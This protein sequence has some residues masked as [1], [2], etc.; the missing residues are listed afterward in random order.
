MQEQRATAQQETKF[1]D[2]RSAAASGSH[3]CVTSGA[4]GNV[5]C[6]GSNGRGQLGV[7]FFEELII[8]P[9]DVLIA[10]FGAMPSL[11]AGM[12]ADGGADAGTTEE[13]WR[14]SIGVD[15]QFTYEDKR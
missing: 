3:L 9:V 15:N 10:D 2:V 12:M 4:A 6:F 8:D 14:S 5:R 1:T 7:G 13:W 11:D